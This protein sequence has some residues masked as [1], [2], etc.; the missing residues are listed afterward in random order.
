MCRPGWCGSWLEMLRVASS[1][2][3]CKKD[4]ISLFSVNQ[5]GCHLEAPLCWA[6]V[7]ARTRPH[8]H[9]HTHSPEEGCSVHTGGTEIAAKTQ[10]L[11]ACVPIPSGTSYN[12]LPWGLATS[13]GSIDREE[14]IWL[15]IGSPSFTLI[16]V[17][18]CFCYKLIT[19]GMLPIA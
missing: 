2:S 10:N 7:C 4:H 17:F 19:K 13:L 12:H 1:T 15:H 16:F 6:A 5:P 9:T 11:R 8:K 14:Q 3:M 18:Y